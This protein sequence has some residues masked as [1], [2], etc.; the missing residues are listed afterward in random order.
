MPKSSE[1]LIKAKPNS[2]KIRLLK[3][4]FRKNKDILL[5]FLFGSFAKGLVTKESDFDIAVYLRDPKK[6]D[7]IWLEVSKII[8]K[9][10]D[11]VCLNEAPASLVSN[12]FKTGIP[13]AIK[14]RKLYW[15]LYL[16]KS[17]EAEDFL[18][19]LRDF[20]RIKQK[21]KSLNREEQG[22]LLIRVDYLKEELKELDR[23]KSLSWENYL[24]D[25]DKRKLIERWTENILNATIDI[26]KMILASEKK[27]M[28][29]SYEEALFDFAIFIGFDLQG[30]EKFA[31]FANLRNLLAHE[32]LDIL[33][34]KI[35]FFLKEAPDFY[36]KIL[37]FLDSYLEKLRD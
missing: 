36:Q 9:E 21:A 1:G 7:E 2:K 26:A 16:Q 20:W 10:V 23:F 19:F 17:S 35:Q 5:A 3:E 8:Q 14:D 28:P 33:Y 6:E 27:A 31:K 34:Q 13:L 18:Y 30:A 25:R 32:Y 22:R 4:Y 15:E 24:K 11:L 12:V 37:S 29:K